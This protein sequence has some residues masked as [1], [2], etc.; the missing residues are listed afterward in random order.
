VAANVQFKRGENYE[1]DYGMVKKLATF[2]LS[3]DGVN[4]FRDRDGEFGLS[5]AFLAKGL[6]TVK[7]LPDD[8]NWDDEGHDF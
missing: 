8:E 4:L 7:H 2:L 1:I 3:K 6:V 5:D